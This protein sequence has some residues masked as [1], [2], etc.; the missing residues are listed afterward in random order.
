MF[1]FGLKPCPLCGGEAE[2]ARLTQGPD[3]LDA[4]IRC[5]DCGLTLEWETDIKVGISRSGKR[6]MAKAGLDPIE[7]WN[8]RAPNCEACTYCKDCE[9]RRDAAQVAAL[10]NCNDCGNAAGCDYVPTIG[11]HVRINCPLWRA[12]EADQ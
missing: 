4:V 12:M 6:T 2:V 3:R 11:Q 7:A 1:D 10:P 8:R 5:T 9:T